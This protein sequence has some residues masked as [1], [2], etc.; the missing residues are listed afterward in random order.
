MNMKTCRRFA[1]PLAVIAALFCLSSAPAA[2]QTKFV[3]NQNEFIK[4]NPVIDIQDFTHANQPPALDFLQCDT[5]V[6]SN[7]SD[8]CFSPGDILE[9]ISFTQSP[10][11]DNNI[12]LLGTDSRGSQNP[13]FVLTNNN[14][15]S[16]FVINFDPAVNTVGL[17]MGCAEVDGPCSTG[18]N[19]KIYGSSSALGF[20][21]V[22]VTNDFDT[23]VGMTT[24]EPIERVVLEPAGGTQQVRGVQSVY[25]GQT[26]PGAEPGGPGGSVNVP[27]LSEWGMIAAAVGFAF[28]GVFYALRRRKASA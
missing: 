14:F 22:S 16:D 7:S 23:F 18:V 13:P 26:E 5:P 3:Y 11:P 24:S 12:L 8:E 2:A 25:F 19:V 20:T 10:D 15:E 1:A 17:N 21:S 9:G 28:V 4:M 27:T 6:N